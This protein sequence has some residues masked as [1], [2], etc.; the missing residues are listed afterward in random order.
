MIKTFIQLTILAVVLA[1]CTLNA[2]QEASLNQSVSKYVYARNECA[3]VGLVGFTYP[4]FIKELKEQ[5]DSVFLQK[6]DC[7]EN[8]TFQIELENPTLRTVEK[9]GS[10]M[11]VLYEFD[12]YI[13]EDNKPLKEKK[14]LVAISENEGLNWFFMP[15]EDY[16]DTK[17]CTSLKRLLAISK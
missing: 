13:R 6:F 8:G 9:E 12:A 17:N 14:K 11:H 16:S 15:F 4:P 5:G 2:S 1:S 7:L 3:L 10:N